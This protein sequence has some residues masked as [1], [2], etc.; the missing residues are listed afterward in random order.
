MSSY[1][2]DLAATPPFDFDAS[3]RFVR[4][5]PATA[6]EQDVDA[7]VLREAVRAG[8]TVA[9][10]RVRASGDGLRYDVESA[11]PLPQA[12]RAEIGD[13]VRNRFGLD[14]DL[15]PF[16]ERAREDPPFAAVVA[17][18]H[19]YHQVRFASPL[20]LLCWAVLCQRTPTAVARRAK[21]AIAAARGNDVVLDGRCLRAFPDLQQLL[22]F[23]EDDLQGLVGNARKARYLHGALR[24]WA[25]L[26]E[27]FLRHGDPDEVRD[28][29]CGLP[30]I[31]PWSAGFV[32]IRGLG[33]TERAEPDREALTAATR[34]YGRPVDAGE[35]ARLAERYGDHRGYW[36][37][38][39]RVG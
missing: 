1:S 3:L 29:L 22:A 9:G 10:L 15:A 37:H 39:L 24:G 28:A 12:A 35:F 11:A 31:G 30:G 16:Y 27:D 32:M 33:R 18:L 17:R 21:A 25:E 26:D 2:A 4:A 13:R 23:S 19:G 34:V 8:G 38:Y 5:F 7:G 14:D 6:G 36:M 20:E